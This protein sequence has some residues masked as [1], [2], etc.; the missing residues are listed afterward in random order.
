MLIVPDNIAK[1]I[2]QVFSAAQLQYRIGEAN[3]QAQDQIIGIIQGIAFEAKRDILPLSKAA[4]QAGNV[5]I[6]S[7]EY[8]QPYDIIDIDANKI[9]VEVARVKRSIYI[10]LEQVCSEDNLRQESGT[11]TACR[12]LLEDWGW[13]YNKVVINGEDI[14]TIKVGKSTNLLVI[15]VSPQGYD[16]WNNIVGNQELPITFTMISPQGDYYYFYRYRLINLGKNDRTGIQLLA[17]ENSIVPGPCS[18]DFDIAEGLDENDMP[19]IAEIPEWLYRSLK[20][21]GIVDKYSGRSLIDLQNEVKRRRLA[22][23]NIYPNKDE[24]I[25]A[26]VNDDLRRMTN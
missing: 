5:V 3:P 12:Q 13:Q 26:L 22:T 20:R 1:M 6:F 11:I 17:E 25:Q 23:K 9:T 21:Q 18:E 24:A 4:N 15:K 16:A 8:I 2:Q 7:S 14:V 10:K 19:I